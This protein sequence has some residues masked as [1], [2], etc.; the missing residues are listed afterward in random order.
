MRYLPYQN[1]RLDILYQLKACYRSTPKDF[2]KIRRLKRE[3]ESIDRPV[4][5]RLSEKG[6][7]K[8]MGT[9]AFYK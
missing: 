8:K 3:L 1:R 7:L 5:E 6:L 2:N 4:K 9:I